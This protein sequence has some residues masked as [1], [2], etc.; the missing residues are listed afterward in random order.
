MKTV[1]CVLL[2]VT[3]A[4]SAEPA[5][6]EYGEATK[7]RPGEQL[8]EASCDVT[9]ELA[10]TIAEVRIRERIVNPGAGKLAPI[11]ELELP[12]GAKLVGVTARVDVGKP[13][14]GLL[15]SAVPK[16]DSSS[17][18]DVLGVDPAFVTEIGTSRLHATRFRAQL[19]P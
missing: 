1:A 15:V 16:P 4:A 7:L 6:Y 14:D 2:A 13:S 3:R 10:G 17:T 18:E 5:F 11:E 8:V 19:L 9:V 12:P